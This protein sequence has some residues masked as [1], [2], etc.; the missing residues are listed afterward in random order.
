MDNNENNRFRIPMRFEPDVRFSIAP[1]P[2]FRG[3]VD[4]ELERLKNALVRCTLEGAEPELYPVIRR[5]ANEAMALAWNTPF[6]T[7][8]FPLLFEEKVAEG[9]KFYAKQKKIREKTRRLLIQTV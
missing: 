3:M 6:P 8:F 2:G 9:K 4:N 7:L 1:V 5:A